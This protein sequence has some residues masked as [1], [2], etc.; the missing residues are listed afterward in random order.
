ML[1]IFVEEI[2]VDDKP[3]PLNYTNGY[4]YSSHRIYSILV[5]KI[6]YEQL[7]RQRTIISLVTIPLFTLMIPGGEAKCTCHLLS[8]TSKD[9]TDVSMSVNVFLVLSGGFQVKQL[10]E[11]VDRFLIQQ[12]NRISIFNFMR[13]LHSI[14]E[15]PGVSKSVGR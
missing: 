14:V 7:S 4:D 15:T 13:K 5:T 10:A 1:Y 3:H 8:K 11:F 6:F 2:S 12:Q 9:D